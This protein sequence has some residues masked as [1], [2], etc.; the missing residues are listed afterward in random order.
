MDL[1]A[2]IHLPPRD[3]FSRTEDILDGKK[4]RLRTRKSM[5]RRLGTMTTDRECVLCMNMCVCVREGE[6]EHTHIQT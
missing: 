3:V 6:Q 2:R 1:H 5:E 4:T